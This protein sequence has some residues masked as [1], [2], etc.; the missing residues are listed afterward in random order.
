MKFQRNARISRSQMD[1]TPFAGVFFCLLIFMLLASLVYT[2]GVSISLPVSDRALQGVS[3]PSVAVAMDA[4]GVLY[5]HNQL[6]T[7]T[8]LMQRLIAE[9]QRQAEPLTLVL[10]ADKSVTLQQLNHFR[11]IAAAAGIEQISQ[12]VLPRVYDLRQGVLRP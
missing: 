1:V 7:E 9:R 12:Q 11:D 5:F 10:Q 4:H 6:V 3:G 8:N 2:P